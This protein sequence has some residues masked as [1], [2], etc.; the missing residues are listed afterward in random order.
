MPAFSLSLSQFLR[1]VF[2]GPVLTLTAIARG[3]EP[4]ADASTLNPRVTGS[5]FIRTW[6]ADEYGANPENTCVLQHPRTGLIY[7]G[8]R[9]GLLEF[10][11]VRWRLIPTPTGE[12][13]SSLRVDERGRIWGCGG[14]QI[15]RL[16]PDE[17]GL[18]QTRSMIGLLPT[19]THALQITNT[20]VVTT[21]G[22][23]FKDQR[24]LIRFPHD[25]GPPRVWRLADG[26]TVVLQL[27]KIADDPYVTVG[28][29]KVFRV[30]SGELEPV[31]GFTRS[32]FETRPTADGGW[33]GPSDVGLERWTGSGFATMP[34]PLGNDTAKNATLL[35]DG[36][37]VFATSQS[38]LVVCDREGHFL[39]K[40][41]RT[42]G[43]PANHVTGVMEDREGGVWAALPYGIA[44]VQL[45]SPY[46]RHGPAEGLEG[47]IRS[48]V[49]QGGELF[50]GGTEGVGRRGA[51]GRFRPVLDDPGPDREIVAHGDRL[52]SLAGQL[53]GLQPARGNQIRVLENRNYYGLLP[54]AGAPGW[55]AHGSNQGLRW[56]HFAG[57]QWISEG[58]LKAIRGGAIALL[59]APAGI[60]WATG[61]GFWRVDFR[62]GLRVDAPAHRFTAGEGVARL[63][64]A[65]FQLGGDVMAVVAGKLLR[66]DEGAGSFAPETRVTG[67]ADYAIESA[68]ASDDGTVWLQGAP[69]AREIRHLVPESSVSS[70]R[71][72]AETLPGASLRQLL[73]T[74]LYHEIATQTLWIAGHGA[75]ISRDLT[76]RPTRPLTP[77]VVAVRRI[78]TS[79]GELLAAGAR[80]A[81]G[82][83]LPALPPD[84]DALRISFAAPV[85]AADRKGVVPIEYRTRLD[86]LDHEWSAWTK[87]TERD[88]TNLP[89]RAFTFRA[90]ARDE[91]GQIG[92]ET[93]VIFSIRPA[94]WATRWAW[95]GYGLMGLAGMMGIVRWRTRALHW[96]ADRL[97]S[98]IAS[99]THEIA[100]RNEQ[101]AT[102]N[103]EL[104]RLH[105]LELDEK[106]AAQLSEEKARL[107]VLRYQLN[108]HFLYNSLNSIYGLLF[109][110][111]RD[112]GEMVLRLSEFCR[113]TLTGPKD[114]LPTLGTE[115]GALRSYLDVEKVRWGEN[116]QVE[117]DVTPEVE[118]VRLP[119][120]L[121]LPLVENAVKY[122]SR[123]TP[124]VLR[125]HISAHRIDGALLIEVA[126]TGEWLPPDSTRAESTGIGLENLRQRLE[127]YYPDAH[128]FTTAA[129][130][131]W[132]RA[133]LRLLRDLRQAGVAVAGPETV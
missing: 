77:P 132:V 108:P 45:D 44:R 10:D 124:G 92:P 13:V 74:T 81:A 117:F 130:N 78:E 49:R 79:A 119:P 27:W 89:W 62:A 67:L 34:R 65:M 106:I 52:Y 38:G 90:Q 75:L 16:E 71:W 4:A 8:N 6:L 58:S 33:E 2:L 57:D 82:V 50:A 24:H 110:N 7:V 28:A 85:F 129:E 133:R 126:N 56:A 121:L 11:G 127:R 48:V 51:D 54:L 91:A 22:L 115:I 86:G 69:P 84:R 43:L 31:V 105:R 118:S 35:A 97:E 103:R 21:Q 113:A 1:R 93:S 66:Y 99:R 122:G 94:W 19:D 26:N 95:V 30:H 131:G 102:S 15:F 116:L 61:G 111:A 18:L 59:E 9:S 112:A 107:E 80:A 41:D 40:I 32:L 64:S 63:P 76:W 96:R 25:D 87:Q 14:S 88:F 73:P 70:E 60:V 68:R 98:I 55:F 5:P 17:H 37:V 123:T 104:A 53:R 36:R 101:L 47:T 83:G 39:Q 29:D 20:S 23:F 46:A 114:E 100:E 12:L 109:E 3:A 125:L 120:F 72:R 42:K 128:A